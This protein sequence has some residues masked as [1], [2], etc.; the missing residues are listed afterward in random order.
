VTTHG[1]FVFD[2]HSVHKKP[3]ESVIIARKPSQ[4]VD[5]EGPSMKRI[6]HEDDMMVSSC[7]VGDIPSSFMFMCIPSTTHSQKPYL[8]DLLQKFIKSDK[9][10]GLEL[11]ARNLLPGWTSWGNEVLKFQEVPAI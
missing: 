6:K 2:V 11:F 7:N 5:D 8:G 9:M 1:E 10:K 4:E 3:Y